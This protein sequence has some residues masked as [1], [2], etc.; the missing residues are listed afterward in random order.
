MAL[1]Y[2]SVSVQ[3]LAVQGW[4]LPWDLNSELFKTLVASRLLGRRST[5]RATAP[6]PAV[7]GGEE[8]LP[9][10]VVGEVGHRPMRT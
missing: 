6:A 4:Q 7:W 5:A 1:I 8:A 10:P 2:H 3:Q 9:I